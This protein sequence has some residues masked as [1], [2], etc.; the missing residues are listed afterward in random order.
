MEVRALTPSQSPSP[1]RL[2]GTG[3]G[4][5][6]GAK[7]SQAKPSQAITHNRHRACWAQGA[8]RSPPTRIGWVHA[9]QRAACTQ[10]CARP[11][12]SSGRCPSR[13]TSPQELLV[14]A[15]EACRSCCC[16][17]HVH[18]VVPHALGLLAAADEGKLASAAV[19]D[20]NPLNRPP[21]CSAA[22]PRGFLAASSHYGGA[23]SVYVKILDP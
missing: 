2:P 5:L 4:R 15:V 22:L 21:P 10:P 7:P 20:D 19:L 6:L 16:G 17:F 1:V 13:H 14:H 3:T 18:L 9:A 12:R 23:V 11:L 8:Q